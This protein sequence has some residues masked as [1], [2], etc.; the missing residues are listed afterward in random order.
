ML[1]DS[2]IVKRAALFIC[3]PV[4]G[5]FGVAAA[6]LAGDRA[7][8]V[9]E[10]AA[11]TGIVS[12]ES[13]LSH[14]AYLSDDELEGRGIG[15]EGI[16]RA[17]EYVARQFRSAGLKPGGDERG[18]FQTFDLELWKRME[19]DTAV[20]FRVGDGLPQSLRL[21][22]DATPLPWTRDG[23]ADAGVV[24][25]G[26]GI[27]DEEAGYDDYDGPA[28]EDKIVLMLRYEPRF[29]LDDPDAPNRHTP[30][31]Q[32]RIKARNAREKG[33]AGV[34][35][36]NPRRDGEADEL[37]PFGRGGRSH[38]GISMYQLTRETADRLLR[39]GGLPDVASLQR[40]I[41]STQR[42]CSAP[43]E[44]V[45]VQAVTA[46]ASDGPMAK[47]VIGILPGKGPDADEFIVVGA[48]YD[49]LGNAPP[50]RRPGGEKQIHNGADDNASGTAAVI[51]L[52]TLL[53]D[54]P[55]LNR[56]VMLM[57]YTA[58]ETGLLGSRHFVDNPTVPLED[59]VAMFNMD[60]IGRMRDER[61]QVGGQ[62][63]A[64]KFEDMVRR[65]GRDYGFTI[66]DGGGGRGPSD[67]TSFYGRGI[68][69]LFLFTGLHRQ[70]HKPDDDVELINAADGARITQWVGD[71]VYEVSANKYRPSFTEDSR[72]KPL[73]RAQARMDP[74]GV[75][76]P[77]PQGRPR[78]GI[79]PGAS[80]EGGVPIHR[81]VAD[82]PAERAGLE[83]GDVIIRIGEQLVSGLSELRKALA[84]VQDGQTVS[85]EIRRDGRLKLLAVT[86]GEPKQ[87][88]PKDQK[89]QAAKKAPSPHAD[90]GEDEAPPMPG[91]RLGIAPTYAGGDG[92]A[93]GF[94]IEYVV[95]GGA[96][97]RAGMRDSDRILTIGG[98]KV[99]DVY[100][101]MESLAGY[102]PGD[103]IDVV[104][105]RDG[106]EV[107]LKLKADPPR[108]PGQ[109]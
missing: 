76:G 101:Y 100:S 109:S 28:V 65:W 45:T 77:K 23:E 9:A 2:P 85:I 31:A 83:P 79:L 80:D 1:I 57:A 38:F 47:N 75:N 99:W 3:L 82:T 58:E 59:I 41:E 40:K 107:T 7:G 17:A 52:A 54:G 90:M 14:I 27:V 72:R 22:V 36:V 46:L 50:M 95:E 5:L 92:E 62:R 103:R 4:V 60:M 88:E 89:A 18:Y 43:L 55:P 32:F 81:V 48:H 104:V 44:D 64:A 71:M 93:R 42:P 8:V 37:I 68:P 24:F 26:Y 66:E 91:V 102:K 106:R 30:H 19:D 73:L 108:Q 69:V 96:A 51:E 53:A 84:A 15:S 49:H 39:A 16:D 12:A 11:R 94:E 10:R 29:M 33:A 67:H 13:Y 61:I 6:A 74:E 34:L 21:G 56:S 20:S 105:L 63:T 25:V 35:I 70:Y 78:L 97:E 87:S 98:K 86:L